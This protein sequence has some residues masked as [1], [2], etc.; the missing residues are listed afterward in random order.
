MKSIYLGFILFFGIFQLLIGIAIARLIKIL[1]AVIL[2]ACI[3]FE[4][5]WVHC[6][7]TNNTVKKE[8]LLIIRMCHFFSYANKIY[9]IAP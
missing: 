3:I 9:F 4:G 7:F 2:I 6:S 5:R 1:A 8:L